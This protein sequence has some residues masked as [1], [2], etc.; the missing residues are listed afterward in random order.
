[1]SARSE[2]IEAIQKIDPSFNPTNRSDAFLGGYLGTLNA[3]RTDSASAPA[4]QIAQ[5]FEARDERIDSATR[6]DGDP[7]ELARERSIAR[8]AVAS[9]KTGFPWQT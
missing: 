3:S 6:V 4:P 7:A 9:T 8:R 1:M 2:L 5:R